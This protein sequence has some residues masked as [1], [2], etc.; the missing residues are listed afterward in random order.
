[1]ANSATITGLKIDLSA[2]FGPAFTGLAGTV[3]YTIYD[4]AGVVVVART[5]AGIVELGVSGSYAAVDVTPPITARHVTWDT[6][7]GTPSFATEDLTNIIN[8]ENN[9]KRLWNQRETDSTVDPSVER[10][11]DDDDST[12]IGVGNA[13]EDVAGNRQYRERGINRVNRRS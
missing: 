2:A 12:P 4:A 6:G 9:R 7:G 10:I 1:M 3:G 11:L 13:F 8:D 5:T